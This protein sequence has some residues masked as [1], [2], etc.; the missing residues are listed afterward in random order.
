MGKQIRSKTACQLECQEWGLGKKQPRGG[1]GQGVW[2]Q[3]LSA[4]SFPSFLIRRNTQTPGG[5][6]EWGMHNHKVLALWKPQWRNQEDS[7]EH[8]N[9]QKRIK[10]RIASNHWK[11]LGVTDT[12]SYLE[13]QFHFVNFLYSPVF[14]VLMQHRNNRVS[15]PIIYIIQ[16]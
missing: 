14:L 3:A 13:A 5:K 11:T 4:G 15:I 7:L 1:S 10:F 8:R 9:E 2:A 16:S 6:K 12:L